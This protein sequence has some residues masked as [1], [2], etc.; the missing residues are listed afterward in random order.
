MSAVSALCRSRYYDIRLGIVIFVS[1]LIF[2][3]FDVRHDIMIMSSAVADVDV[4]PDGTIC[5]SNLQVESA[6]QE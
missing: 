1:T 2:A 5:R 3:H 4:R 6:G